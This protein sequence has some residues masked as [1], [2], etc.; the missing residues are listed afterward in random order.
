MSACTL[1]AP[2]HFRGPSPTSL[3]LVLLHVLNGSRGPRQLGACTMPALPWE[4]SGFLSPAYRGSR[5]FRTKPSGAGV[6][7]PGGGLC[8]GQQAAVDRIFLSHVQGA[9]VGSARQAAPTSFCIFPLPFSHKAAFC[10][11]PL[12]LE[13]SCKPSPSLWGPPRSLTA[14]HFCLLGAG[15]S[16]VSLMPSSFLP[17]SLRPCRS[18]G[19]SLCP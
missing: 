15:H 8:R 7:K 19:C 17:Q 2:A 1:N 11:F 5:Q 9:W 16:G 12:H 6:G 10:G 14:P 18:P 4:D 3:Q 13:K